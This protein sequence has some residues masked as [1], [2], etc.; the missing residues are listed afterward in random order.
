MSRLGSLA[1][2]GALALV[3][4]PAAAASSPSHAPLWLNR[5]KTLDCGI[6]LPALSKKLVLCSGGGI[7]RPRH[8]DVNEG[9]PFVQIAA[10]GKP[11]LVLISQ[12]VFAATKEST[13]ASG[14]TWSSRGVTCQVVGK[15]ALCFNRSNHGFL[16]GSGHYTSF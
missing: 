10:T 13:L 6:A 1:A 14:S 12:D 4:A 7:P 5:A 2:L 3:T 15:T 11:Q 16:I 8:S 9:D